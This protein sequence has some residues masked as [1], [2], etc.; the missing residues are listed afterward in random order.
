MSGTFHTCQSSQEPCNVGLF[1]RLYRE[2]PEAP[3]PETQPCH[4]QPHPGHFSLSPPRNVV[5]WLPAA[6]SSGCPSPSPVRSQQDAPSLPE[7]GPDPSGS[8]VLLGSSPPESAGT[9]SSTPSPCPPL[10]PALPL[11]NSCPNISRGLPFPHTPGHH[12]LRVLVTLQCTLL[13]YLIPGQQR[14]GAPCDC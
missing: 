7:P 2:E 8:Q 6:N 5:S 11:P 9:P 3:R 14:P 13:C 12:V 1:S 4:S 10:C